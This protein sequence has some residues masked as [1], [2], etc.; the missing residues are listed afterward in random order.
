MYPFNA[1]LAGWLSMLMWH[2]P[3]PDYWQLW[4]EQTM[5]SDVL[6]NICGI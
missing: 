6:P 4:C 1:F 2:H 3:Q 5:H